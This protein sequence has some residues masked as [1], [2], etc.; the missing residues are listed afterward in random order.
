MRINEVTKKYGVSPSTLRYYEQIK[1][2][3]EIERVNGNRWYEE[4]DLRRLEFIF[5][6]KDSNMSLEKM[7]D[8][9]DLIDQGESTLP[10]RLDLLTQHKEET[11]DLM[12]KIQ[13]SLD[14]I[15]H[16][17]ELTE[18]LMVPLNKV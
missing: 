4:Q 11:L 13:S 9:F 2:L 8:Y 12:K 10:A 16:K 7:K 18:S 5:C 6:M 14:Y 3:P 17:I 1:L 15:E